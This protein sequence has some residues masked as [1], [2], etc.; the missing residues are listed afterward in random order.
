MLSFLMAPHAASEPLVFESGPQKT[1]MVELF[2]SQGCSSC[3]PAEAYLNSF[4][5]DPELWK[6]VIPVAFHVD[7]WDYI[8]WKDPF[9]RPEHASR[10]Q[11]YARLGHVSSVYT[12]A[13]I[14]NGKGRRPGRL[15]HNAVDTP[16]VGNL[17]INLENGRVT[18]SF[19]PAGKASGLLTLH[20]AVLGMNLSTDIQAGENAGRHSRHEFVL[21]G[22]RKARSTERKWTIRLPEFDKSL[23]RR[24]AV[25]AWLSRP[26]DP[27]PLQATGGY[28]P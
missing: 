23:T 10:Q 15:G 19:A 12:P 17:R 1:V 7:Y 9:A 26:G 5:D 22:H 25:I 6:R 2:T 18:A 16:A 11:R 4:V 20:L 24:L 27:S 3:P 8:G 28:L 14:V 13:L 21:L